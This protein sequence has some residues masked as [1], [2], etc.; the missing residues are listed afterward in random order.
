MDGTRGRRILV[1]IVVT[2]VGYLV[3]TATMIAIG[4]LLTHALDSS[5]G[6]W[7][8][9]VAEFFARH[10]SSGVN[11][12]TKRATSGVGSLLRVQHASLPAMIVAAIVVVI[13]ARL[14]RWREG[15][16]FAI[17][18]ALEFIAYRTIVHFVARQRPHVFDLDRYPSNTSYPSGHTAAATVLF[19]GI[20]LIVIS[21]TRNTVARVLAAIVAVV[22]TAIVGFARVYRGSH[23][24]VDVLAGVM[25]GLACLA[26]A[27]VAVRSMRDPVATT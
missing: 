7:D 14:G 2:I 16:F 9:S 27:A 24:L 18:F 15:A 20:L 3:V 8:R 17:A 12:V 5:V 10:R 1:A 11:S 26:V 4:K 13:L 22:G 6:D 25:L 19:V 23:S 21:T